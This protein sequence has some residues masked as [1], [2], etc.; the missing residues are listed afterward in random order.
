M[1]YEGMEDHAEN[2]AAGRNTPDMS[3]GSIEEP[4][5]GGNGVTIPPIAP[6]IQPVRNW[7][8]PSLITEDDDM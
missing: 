3:L 5:E 6:K 4:P 7:Y 2:G 8:T 1:A